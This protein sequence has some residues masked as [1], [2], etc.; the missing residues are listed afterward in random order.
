MLCGLSRLS[1]RSV[2][3]TGIF[4]GVALITA[5]VRGNFP[6]CTN[7]QPCYTPLYPSTNELVFM[8]AAVAL[9]QSIN[10]IIVPKLFRELPNASVLYNYIAGIQFGLGLLISGMA[11]PA[12]VLGF[13]SW[14][15]SSR[16]DPSLALVM[17]FGVGPSLLKFL[18]MKSEYGNEKGKKSPTLADR[19][20]LP[21]ATV[22]DIDM[23]FVFGAIVFGIGW[24]LCG[25]CPGPGLLR[26]VMQPVWGLWW[27]GG[28]QLGSWLGL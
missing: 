4:F 6:S 27:M 13:F 5:N 28:F 21:T 20:Q 7:G 11:D 22:S 16:L 18:S 23:R 26:T 25:V 2:I 3:A 15:D 14:G 17:L 24:G 9:A 10:S 8:S 19:F 1:P 12:K